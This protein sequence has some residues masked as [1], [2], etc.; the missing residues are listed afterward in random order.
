MLRG[1]VFGFARPKK[2]ERYG[3]AELIQG[4]VNLLI[5]GYCGEAARKLISYLKKRKIK[6]LYLLATHIHYDHV[7]GLAQIV[8]DGYFNVKAIYCYDPVT[9]KTGL[10]N[11]KGSRAAREDIEAFENFITEAKAK[12][13]KV[14][15]LKHGDK[16]TLGDIKFKVYRQQPP[17]VEDDDTEA[18]SYIND[19]SLCIYFYELYYL[20]SGDGSERLYDFA[21][22]LGLKVK[23]FKIPHHGNN[24]TKLQAEGFKA[25]GANV[26]WYNDLEPNGVGTCDFTAYGARRCKEAGIKVLEAVGDINWIAKSGYMVIYKGSKK[27]TYPIKYQGKS[28]LKSPTVNIIRKIFE[29][30]FSSGDR[31]NT[32]LIDAG[33]YPLAAQNKVNMVIKV[34]K[35][36]I[37][38][39][40]DFG[41]NETRLANLDKKYGKGYGQLIQDEINSLL[42]AKSKKW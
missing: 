41:T 3:D 7:D 39:K 9:L 23:Y 42:N 2:E 25:D 10:R 40:V 14:V 30:K 29:K 8:R 11:N 34:A 17:V 15:Y 18:Y 21:K 20:T 5:D 16:V 37:S 24:C 38:K 35:D 13:I 22:S 32:L 6:D 12:G 33:Y 27:Y 36:I 1:F 19:G 28:T 31:R 26:C 4:K